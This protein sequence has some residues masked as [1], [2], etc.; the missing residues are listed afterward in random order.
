M[1]SQARSPMSRSLLREAKDCL[2]VLESYDDERYF[3]KLIDEM[4]AKRDDPYA[5]KTGAKA[6]KTELLDYF[7]GFGE[8]RTANIW[9]RNIPASLKE[10]KALQKALQKPLKK[11]FCRGVVEVHFSDREINS[12]HLQ[13]VGTNAQIAQEIIAKEVVAR[14]FEL[15]YQNAVGK[16][17]FAPYFTQNRLARTNL[18]D[19]VVSYQERAKLSRQEAVEAVVEEA[20]GEEFLD[21]SKAKTEEIISFAKEASRKAKTRLK[22]LDASHKSVDELKKSI[23]KLKEKLGLK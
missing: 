22:E 6:V 14:G 17:K 10:I 13:Y 8:V 11:A 7:E 20:F 21:Q 15:N 19:G 1:I 2:L 4:I 23:E 18:I 9:A 16:G 12:P 3:Y 5:L